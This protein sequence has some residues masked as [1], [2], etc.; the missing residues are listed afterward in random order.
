MLC[1]ELNSILTWTRLNSRQALAT[2]A[3]EIIRHRLPIWFR[4]RVLLICTS[5]TFWSRY[6]ATLSFL[7]SVATRGSLQLHNSCR[8][9]ENP[10]LCKSSLLMTGAEY[11]LTQLHL[12]R[13]CSLYDTARPYTNLVTSL[14][15]FRSW[16]AKHSNI[17]VK[18]HIALTPT[19]KQVKF[20]TLSAE[21]SLLHF[22]CQRNTYT[23][24]LRS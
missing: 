2:V 11:K 6:H 15:A 18:D 21:V 14:D 19:G 22:S 5:N 10:W 4:Y 16:V 24:S 17:S 7:R 23:S 1:S 8:I 20:N 3:S 12:H 9:A 13:E